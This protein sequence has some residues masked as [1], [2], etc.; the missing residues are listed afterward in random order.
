M[1]KCRVCGNPTNREKYCSDS[2]QRKAWK[3]R[4][5]ERYLLGKKLYR[6]KNKKK[7]NEYNRWYKSLGVRPI[8]I[9]KKEEIILNAGNI[10]QRC[11]SKENLNVHH[12]I[13]HWKGGKNGSDNLMVLCWD[14]HMEWTKIFKSFWGNPEEVK[15]AS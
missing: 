14:C 11:G 7:I 3:I 6:Q 10:C 8:S 15:N 9:K 13:P 12:V 2:C 5:R 1:I 4:N